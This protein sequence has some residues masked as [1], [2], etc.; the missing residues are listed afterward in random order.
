MLIVLRFGV[1]TLIPELFGTI[2]LSVE[3][4]AGCVQNT[5]PNC[6]FYR[7]IRYALVKELITYQPPDASLGRCRQPD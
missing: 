6:L 4:A 7:N 5:Q 1:Q 2:I 3:I